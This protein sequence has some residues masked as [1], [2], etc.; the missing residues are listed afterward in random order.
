M[1]TFLWVVDGTLNAVE[2]IKPAAIGCLAVGALVLAHALGAGF[3]SFMQGRKPTI[4]DRVVGTVF[5]LFV[6]AVTLGTAFAGAPFGGLLIA[7]VAA[8]ACSGKRPKE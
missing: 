8:C 6:L 1:E 3:I 5:G 7:G 2:A 4:V